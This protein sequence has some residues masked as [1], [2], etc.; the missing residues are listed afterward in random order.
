MAKETKAAKSVVQHK[1]GGGC[2]QRRMTPA[3]QLAGGGG[4]MLGNAPV[5]R[6]H[7]EKLDLLFPGSVVANFSVNLLCS[8]PDR[9][10]STWLPLFIPDFRNSSRRC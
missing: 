4:N 5:C 3:S 6:G 7:M 1:Q 2:C 10:P 8:S 9:R